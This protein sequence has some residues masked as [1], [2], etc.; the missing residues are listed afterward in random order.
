[1]NPEKLSLAAYEKYRVRKILANQPKTPQ[2]LAGKNEDPE[3]WHVVAFTAAANSGFLLLGKK[4][5]VKKPEAAIEG[6][7]MVEGLET[8]PPFKDVR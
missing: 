2:Q 5:T 8:E 6:R 7:K 4:P 3:R 1:M